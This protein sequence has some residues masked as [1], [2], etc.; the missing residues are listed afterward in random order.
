MLA[1]VESMKRRGYRLSTLAA[2]FFLVNCVPRPVDAYFERVIGSA[3]TASLGNAFVGVAD[4]P[5]AV[6]VNPA[7]LALM[8]RTSALATYDD[9]Y[10]VSDVN[11]GSVSA[12]VPSRIGVIG[13]SW[14][15]VG[16]SGALSEN[17]IT[18]AFAR[19]LISTTQ[20]AS[21]SIG[22]SVDY[23]RAAAGA[24]GGAAGLVTGG[25]G[26]LLRPFPVIGIGYA[27]RN[28]RQG[29]LVLVEGGMGTPVRRQQS[30]GLSY[31]WNG[32]VT[33]SLER[34]QAATGDWRN[35]GGMEVVAHPNLYLRG[36]VCDGVA[37]GGFGVL[38]RSVRVDVTMAS[39]ETL[40]ATY[41]F[42]IGW[43]PKV[44]N[45]YAQSP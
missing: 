13:A 2:A 26:V 17:L 1:N 38:W 25:L 11:E 23:Y 30:W 44:K 10:G 7:G 34:R 22:G 24:E 18:V 9:P 28:L 31:K 16:L 4:D 37:S 6:L 14:H 43:L 5:A 15:Y 39:H 19:H 20:D 3:R 29:D 45:P 21:L 40:G 12:A 27:V 33:L 8:G 35:H 36:G 41:L 32:R 42:S